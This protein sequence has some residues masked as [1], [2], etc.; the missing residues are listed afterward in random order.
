MVAT[1]SFSLTTGIAL[2]VEQRLDGVARVEIAAALLGVAER[3]QDLRG[4]EPARAR[5]LL[6]GV[7]QADLADGGRRLALLELERALGQLQGVAA[8]RDGAR[9]H[10]HDL[11]ALRGERG[12]VVEQRGEPLGLERAGRP[13]GQQRRADLDDDALRLRPF[14][15][16]AGVAGRFRGGFRVCVLM[17]CA[18]RQICRS[19]FR[20]CLIAQLAKKR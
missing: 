6:V 11:L 18:C 15:A 9:R 5:Q 3:Q 10:E 19:A 1:V 17:A 2:S 14:G 12:D 13:V 16:G 8:E 4:D 20:P 7:R